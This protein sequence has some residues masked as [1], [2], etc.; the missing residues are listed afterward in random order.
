MRTRLIAVLVL[1]GM[2]IQS[3]N[4][5]EAGAFATE[6]TQLLNHA[7]LVM[8]YIRQGLQLQNE[9][10]M[11]A[12]M[13]RNVQPLPNQDD[14]LVRG[15]QV[16]QRVNRDGARAGLAL[17]VAGLALAGAIIVASML[18]KRRPAA[19][20][21]ITNDSLVPGF[22][23]IGHVCEAGGDD[24]GVPRRARRRGCAPPA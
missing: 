24:G 21:S 23:G 19:F 22:I 5:A 20:R 11:Y 17:V 8:G 14:A 9:I 13:I 4:R 7:Q 6:V 18:R 16:L 12:D 3:P 10:K 15:T 2:A 1:S